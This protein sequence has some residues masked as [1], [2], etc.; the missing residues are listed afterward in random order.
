MHHCADHPAG[1]EADAALQSGPFFCLPGPVR[2]LGA[3]RPVG[4]AYMPRSTPA[5]DRNVRA[6]I[7]AHGMQFLHSTTGRAQCKLLGC[8]QLV[9]LGL[10]AARA[11]IDRLH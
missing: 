8:T 1:H 2:W 11:A 9:C 7:V 5:G 3:G 10:K 6:E 4:V